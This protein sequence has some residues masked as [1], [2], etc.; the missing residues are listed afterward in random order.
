MSRT[1]DRDTLARKRP[2]LLLAAGLVAVGAAALAPAGLGGRTVPPISI[3]IWVAVFIGALAAQRSR[4]VPIGE[5][6]RRLLAFLPFILL[7]ALP[8]ALVSVE[9]RRLETAMGL[10]ARAV[11]ATS[12][13][14]A[15]ATWLGPSGLVAGLRRLHAPD[16][17]VDILADA[18]ASLTVVLRQ[19]RSMLRAREARRPGFGAWPALASAPVRTARG[20]GRLVAALLLRSLERAEAIERARRARGVG[21]T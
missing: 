8:A 6:L 14:I 4:G 16:R 2:G 21:G 12:A 7:L 17:L 9:G 3:V 1:A 5:A 11:S 13:G 18:L 10:T 20:F 19:V 15:L